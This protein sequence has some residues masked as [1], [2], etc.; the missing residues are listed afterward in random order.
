MLFVEIKRVCFHN[1]AVVAHDVEAGILRNYSVR[2]VPS[3]PE[4]R[5]VHD[6]KGSGCTSIN[7]NFGVQ[8]ELRLFLVQHQGIDGFYRTTIDLNPRSGFQKLSEN[9]PDPAA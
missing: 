3:L 2:R 5:K 7:G 1:L 6:P 8:N 9:L 4:I